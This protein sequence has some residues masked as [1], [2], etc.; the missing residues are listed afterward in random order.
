M[1]V[2]FTLEHSRLNQLNLVTLVDNV[3][4]K[5]PAKVVLCVIH[6]VEHADYAEHGGR[7][8]QTLVVVLG[9]SFQAAF[10]LR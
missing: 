8:D 6:D 2:S 7:S 5:L 3:L 9:F 10:L 1:K 4:I